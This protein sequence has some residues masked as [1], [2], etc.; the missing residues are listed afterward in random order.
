[1]CDNAAGEMCPIWPGHRA[2]AH[3][4]YADPSEVQGSTEEKQAAFRKTLHAIRQRVE[5]FTMPAAAIDKLTIQQSARDL[6]KR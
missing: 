2:T 3:W 5:L 4:G 6:A 1:M